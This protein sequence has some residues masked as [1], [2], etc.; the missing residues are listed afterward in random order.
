MKTLPNS[1]D[2]FSLPMELPT[3]TL[4]L[5]ASRAKTLAA[6]ADK[7]ESRR[8][9]EAAYGQKLSVLLAS[10]DQ[11]TSSW[12]TSQTC[13]VALV[14]NEAGGLG[15]FSETW[16]KS[17]TMLNGKAYVLPILEL[18]TT[19]TAYGSSHGPQADGSWPTPSK[20]AR[21]GKQT[22]GSA[23]SLQK[24]VNGYLKDGTKREIVPTPRKMDGRGANVGTTDGA[25]LRRSVSS[26][27]LNLAE[28]TQMGRR[29]FLP[30][31]QKSDNRDRG[32]LSNPSVQ[33]R[34]R[35]G[36]QLNLSQVVSEKSGALNPPWVEWLM[37]FPIGWTDLEDVETP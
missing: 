30:T 14:N 26:F 6:Q 25:L 31:P 9:L 4:S 33:R 1:P 34:A 27:G 18:G 32:N 13:L 23:L 11:N 12:R 8:V 16:P 17:G 24:A 7:L 36:K 10:Y 5:E 35:I 19:E 22:P 21:G 3:S 28:Y 29:G 15:E 2:Q 37:G 20:S